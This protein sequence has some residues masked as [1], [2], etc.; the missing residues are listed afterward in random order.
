MY[1]KRSAQRGG[2]LLRLGLRPRRC[3][4]SRP[5]ELRTR[6]TSWTLLITGIAD[7]WF[8]YCQFGS[9]KQG[10]WTQ[11]RP[12]PDG[13]LPLHPE[14]ESQ[15]ME[16]LRALLSPEATIADADGFDTPG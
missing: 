11:R 7:R 3:L 5:L 14:A 10:I 8:P 2:E 4:N 6:S 9:G 16:L 13:L 15:W 1:S 12:S